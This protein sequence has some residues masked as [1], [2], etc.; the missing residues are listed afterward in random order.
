[1]LLLI[2]SSSKEPFSINAIDTRSGTSVWS[3]KGNE[4][5][6]ATIG[7]VE[8]FG[9]NQDMLL[10]SAKDRPTIN[11]IAVNARD[12]FHIKSV[13]NNP[14]N[15][16]KAV[17]DGSVICGASTGELVS[18]IEGYHR[19]I[20]CICLNSDGSMLFCGA[21]DGFLPDIHLLFSN[22]HSLAVKTICV[23]KNSNTRILSC[24]LDHTVALY[25]LN[26]GGC[27]LKISG[28][29]PFTCCLIN[30]SESSIFL[31][32][33]RG[34][35]LQVDLYSLKDKDRCIIVTGEKSNFPIFRGHKSEIQQFDINFDGSLLS[36][37]DVLGYYFIWD[38]RS[39]QNLKNGLAKGKF[40]NF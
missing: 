13:L 20:T 19:K 3:Y 24:S 15:F 11:M 5:Q 37:G 36:S 16:I 39:T 6:G 9:P 38:I 40:S 1:L 27:I 28:D 21:E 14:V 33:D 29:R 26:M 2:G 10:I 34:D 18:T 30:P 12:R 35:V 32:T 8:L 31:G 23:T 7:C 22:V 17:P 25:S 4:M